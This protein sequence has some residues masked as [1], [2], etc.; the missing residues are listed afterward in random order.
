MDNGEQQRLMR[1]RGALLLH[2]FGPDRTT[3]NAERYRSLSDDE[4]RLIGPWV[5]HDM[6]R[7]LLPEAGVEARRVGFI[8][9]MQACGDLEPPTPEDVLPTPTQ[10]AQRLSVIGGISCATRLKARL[11]EEGWRMSR[12][13]L[14]I[15][16]AIDSGEVEL[17]R[18]WT[19]RLPG[20]QE[21]SGSRS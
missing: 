19:I 3:G 12:A 5:E 16:R 7:I 15:Q 9:M 6:N 11:T 18:D 1:L 20:L 17:D 14:G 10:I 21:E 13:E 4:R 2:V 8:A